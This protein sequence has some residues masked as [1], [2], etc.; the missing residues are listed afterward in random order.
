MMEYT[1]AKL[2][3]MPPQN[4]F[5]SVD[6]QSVN[7]QLMS[8]LGSNKYSVIH[9]QKSPLALSISLKNGGP[10]LLPSAPSM[11]SKASLKTIHTI[12]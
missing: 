3:L 4:H 5:L 12:S 9:N 8:L 6:N 11:I 1:D 10:P 7:N 2:R